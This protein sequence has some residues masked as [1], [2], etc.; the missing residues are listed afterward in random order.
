[1]ENFQMAWRGTSLAVFLI[2]LSA[3]PTAGQTTLGRVAGTVL[4]TSGGVLPG[5]TITLTSEQTNQVQTAVASETGAF[6][7]PQVPVGTYKIDIELQGFKT[8]TFTKVT[9]A[10][11][12]EHSLTARLE[13]GN[14]SENVTVEAGS[15]LIS[16]TSPEV[17]ATVLQRQVLDIPLANRDVT[18]LI[19]MQPGVQPFINRTNTS[20]NGGRP[21]WTQVTLD[22]INIQDNFIRTNSLDFLPNRPT[23]DTVAEFS[24]TTSVSGAE[25][26]GGASSVRMVTPSGSN[27]FTG[28]AFEFNRDAKYAANSFFNNAATPS[29][30]KPEL[31]R[32][33]FGGRLGGPIQKDR[34]FFF[35]YYEGFRQTSQTSQNLTIPTNADF[36]DGVFR[37]AGTDGIVRSVNVMQLSGQTVD[38]KLRSDF[39]SKVPGSSNVNNYDVGNSTAARV[40]NTGGFRFNQTDLNNRDQYGFRFDYTLTTNHRFE[41]TYSYF[42]ETDDRTDLDRITPDRPLVTTSSDPKRMALAWRWIGSSNFQNEVRG[43]FNLAPVQFLSDWVYSGN[44]YT[45]ALGIINPIGGNATAIGFQPQ[46]RYTNTYQINDTANLMLGNHGIQMGGS[47]QRNHVNPYNYA[48]AFPQVNFGYSASAPGSLALQSSQFPGGIN[49]ADLTN[50]NAMAAWLAGT[51]TSVAQTFQVQNQSSGFVSGVPSDENYTL[52]NIA[53]Y[54]QDNWRWKPNFTVRLGLKW[55]YYSPLKEDNNLGFLPILNNRSLDQVML[56]PTTQVT[57]VDGDFYNKDLNNFGPTVGF[58][59]DLT[60]DGRT[61]VRGGYSLTFVNEETVTVGRSAS[62]GNAGLSSASTLGN[63]FARVA[64]GVPVV[65]TPTFLTTRTLADQMALSPTGTL[66]GMDPNLAAPHVHQVSVGIQRE[67]GS[68]TAVEARYVGSFGRSIWRGTDFNQVQI[69]PDFLAD[70]NRARSNGYLAQQAGLAYNPNFNPAVQGSVPLTVLPNFGTALLTNAQV[71]TNLQTNQVGG[72]ADFYLNQRVPGSLSTFMQN[73]G[74]YASQGLANGGFSDFNSLQLELRR[75]F[76]NG[77]F[78]QLAYTFSDTNTDSAGT[79]QNRFE[80]YMDNARPELNTGRSVFHV[81][82]AVGANAIYELPFGIDRKW[83]N[84]NGFVDAFVGGWQ[85]AGIFAWSSGSPISIVSARGTFNRA[86]GRSDCGGGPNYGN[87]ISCNTAFSTMSAEEIKGL[88]GI[89][90]QADGKIF[91]IDPKVVDPVSGRA[92]G[93]DN[94]TNAAGFDGQVFFNPTAGQVGNLPILA[95]DGPAQFRIDFALSKRIRITDRQRFELKGEAFNLTNTPSFFRGDMDINSTT[96]G[97]LTEVNLGSRVVQ[98]SIRYEF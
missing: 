37:Y 35:G 34:L 1:M 88:L 75:R 95:V 61:A 23:S 64:A 55:E 70:F 50:A 6:L 94:L 92:V 60:K 65:P 12:Q 8:A 53:A 63:Q 59:W 26:A 41:A 58:A 51:V 85:V 33:Q 56:D 98:L 20:I 11:A 25:S 14:V 19:K 73:P 69:S 93:A 47:W 5:A 76:R 17:T 97:R 10:V 91:W 36:M 43:G 45:T 44:Q 15:S 18:N 24:I 22:G 89:H 52:D 78:G 87:P 74:I 83:L 86:T 28:S 49:A 39:L 96:F 30:A 3:A 71:I 31:S 84:S 81:T 40:L 13:L 68:T 66:W 2:L 9:V 72:L 77:F 29:V 7:F 32:H 67:I 79:A 42:K 27:R 4:D 57:F 82:H 46:G 80:A 48:G 21:T 16:T 38:S 90:K 62:R 54:V